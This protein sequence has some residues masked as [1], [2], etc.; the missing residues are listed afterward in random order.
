[1]GCNLKAV[2]E[3]LNAKITKCE[4]LDI[5]GEHPRSETLTAVL[6]TAINEAHSMGSDC[7]NTGLTLVWPF[8]C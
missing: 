6:Q 5:T 1:M 2:M 4:S 3:Q 7:I 8:V